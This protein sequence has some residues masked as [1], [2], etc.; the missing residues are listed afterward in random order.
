MLD[1]AWPALVNILDGNSLWFLLLGSLLGFIFAVL[2]GLSGPQVLAL[3]LPV[4]F[5][6]PSDDAII[7]LMG[8][9]GVS[10]FGGSLT[11]ILINAP[12]ADKSGY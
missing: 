5:T 8:A 6:M 7:M 10:A 1:L 4:T 2:P 3:L 12:G 11:T 9:A